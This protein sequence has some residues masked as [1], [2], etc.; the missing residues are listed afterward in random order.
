MKMQTAACLAATLIVGLS[1][2]S[3]PQATTRGQSAHD[4]K[5]ISRAGHTVNT[6]PNR[7]GHVD[8]IH[9]YFHDQHGFPGGAS[10]HSTSG[11]P[12]YSGFA[13]YGACPGGGCHPGHCGNGGHGCPQHYHSY[14]YQR[15]QNLSYPAP[16]AVGGSVVYPYYTHKGPSDF[17]RDDGSVLGN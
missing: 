1:G 5:F 7:S 10:F 8:N 9:G 6:L 12:G 15:P 11:F 16:N 4:T 3:T 14:S 17:F 13:E 2:C